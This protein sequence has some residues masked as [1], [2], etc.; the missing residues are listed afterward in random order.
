MLLFTSPCALKPP[1]LTNTVV[2]F[3]SFTNVR[4]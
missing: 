2:P 4:S 1:W 3:A